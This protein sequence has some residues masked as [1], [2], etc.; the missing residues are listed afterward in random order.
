MKTKINFTQT[1][2][3]AIAFIASTGSL[4]QGQEAYSISLKQ[5]Q[6]IALEKS[7]AVQYVDLDM[8]KS[9]RDVKALLASGL[10]QV[11]LIADYSQYIDIPVQVAAGDVFGF[12]AYLT[13]FFGGVSDATGVGIDAPPIDPD[14]L[15]EFQFGQSHTANYGVTASQLIFSGSYFFGLKASE[16]LIESRNR[17]QQRTADEVMEQVAKAYHFLLAAHEGLDLANE[18]LQLTQG[19]RDEVAVLNEVGFADELLVSQIDLAINNLEAQV[20]ASK[21]QIVVGEGLLRF[22]MGIAPNASLVLTDGMQELM[23][24]GNELEWM[25]RDFM[26][27]ELPGVQEQDLYLRLAGLDVKAQKADGWPKVSAFY[28]NQSNAQRDAFDFFQKN[29]EWYPVQ[30]WGVN[31]S[32]PV[33][34]SFGGRQAVEKKKI[35]AERARIAL[36]QVTQGAS[37]EFDNAQVT[38]SNAVA[39]HNNASKGERL[40]QKIYTQ[41]D[42]RFKE[43]MVSSFDMD[44]ARNQLLEAKI[45]KLT[46]SL[47][48]LNARVALQ[49][50]LSAFE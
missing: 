9:K 35:E 34:T 16:F 49:K 1:T 23:S 47:D 33:W 37:M 44:D 48:W 20:L 32:M 2:I 19:T 31:F 22:Q 6:E 28:S 46:A 21:G 30:L 26:P 38:F 39:L 27:S 24:N 25:S 4:V 10:P 5:A 18:A 13:D 17:R 29:Q 36:S 43:G 11:N 8:E 15:S 40:A 50:A 14:A 45:K 3:V 42:A 7:F 41:S 12:P